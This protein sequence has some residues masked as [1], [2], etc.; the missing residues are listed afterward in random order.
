MRTPDVVAH[1][2]LCRIHRSYH[3]M[4][5]VPVCSMY[6]NETAARPRLAFPDLNRYST[7]S[8]Q[9]VGCAETR[10]KI[11]RASSTP[12]ERTGSMDYGGYGD[13]G[14]YGYG[15][16][17][18]SAYGAPPPRRGPYAP[19][20]IS[21]PRRSMYTSRSS[22]RNAVVYDDFEGEVRNQPPFPVGLA[23]CALGA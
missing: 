12:V 6:S 19:R 18:R 14:D 3:L 15:T 11:A 2:D 23:A 7:R 5:T 22:M 16:I 13:Y 21:S 20:A 9:K 4:N 1:K 17:Q 8:V 10:C